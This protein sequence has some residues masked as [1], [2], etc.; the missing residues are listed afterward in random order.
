MEAAGM[1][2]GP[3]A[4]PRV[5]AAAASNAAF[6]EDPPPYSP[7][8]PKSAQLLFPA[9]FPQPAHPQPPPFIAQP[10]PYTAYVGP[11]GAGPPTA[12]QR[13][14][15]DYL[16]ESVLVTVFCCLLT[17]LAAL[18]YSHETRAALGRGD[19]AR[20]Q[21]AS[22]KAQSLVLLS[23][24]LGLFVSFSWVVYVLVALYW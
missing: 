2:A 20:A 3:G 17:G 16:V 1:E 9:A 19:V 14:P 5:V 8:D 7:P 18:L 6:E 15:K 4:G 23:L 22:K 10:L 12:A 13:P 11:P 21:A 24:L